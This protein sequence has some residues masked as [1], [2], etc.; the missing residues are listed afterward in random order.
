MRTA[1]IVAFALLGA[2]CSK[3][4][5]DTV[6]AAS[7]APQ[8]IAVRTATVA[9]RV[10]ERS[11]SVTGSL[12]PDEIVT[13]SAEVPG[14]VTRIDFDFGQAVR[15][16]Q[17][18]AELDP[19]ELSLQLERARGSLEQAMARVG[20]DPKQPDVIPETTPAMR[21]AWN[22]MEDARVKYENASRLVKTGDVSQERFNEM[23]K[24]YKARMAAF[25]ATRDDLLTQLAVVRSLRA[26]VKLAEKHLRDATVSAPF[27]GT[28]GQKHVT[29]GQY[30]KENVAIVTLVKT[31]PMRLRVDVP[32]S[33]VSFVKIG[34]MLHFTTDAVPGAEFEAVVREVN[35]S[36]DSRSRTLSAEARLLTNDRRLK[37]GSFVQVRM[38][39]SQAVPIIT[40]PRAAVFAVAGLYK[41]FMIENGKA[42][43]QRL[44]DV[45]VTDGW[46]EVPAGKI[47]PG[48]EVAISNVSLLTN[49]AP[50]RRVEGSGK[51]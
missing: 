12:A 22:Q 27:D 51:S 44:E 11:I 33:V 14:R 2:G 41:V 9:S 30:I 13:I 6:K 31:D 10:A 29:V 25:E 5:Q 49:G 1:W 37:P 18:I 47:Q 23:D 46:V 21:Q 35:P 3:K 7:P 20:L 24:A 28:I 40:V 16:G 17:V 48:S 34:T 19:L 8:P 39:A 50:V 43:E 32:E 26:D 15:Q 42:V 4:A 45:T 36:L 38:V